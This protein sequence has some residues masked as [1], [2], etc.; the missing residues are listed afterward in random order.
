MRVFD[1]SGGGV[2]VGRIPLTWNTDMAELAGQE[3]SVELLDAEDDQMTLHSARAPRA[4][5]LSHN[6]VST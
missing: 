1:F 6:L 5:I 4:V 2:C 3:V